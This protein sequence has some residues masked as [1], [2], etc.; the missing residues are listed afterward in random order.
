MTP[1]W[2]QTKQ[3]NYNYEAVILKSRNSLDTCI[4]KADISEV[5]E[6]LQD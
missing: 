3:M 6:I 1:V 4:G 5:T 2:H